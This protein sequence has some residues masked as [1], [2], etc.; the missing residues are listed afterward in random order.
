MAL[1]KRLRIRM[2]KEL[3]KI[4]RYKSQGLD[5]PDRVPEDYLDTAF[6]FLSPKERLAYRLFSSIKLPLRKLIP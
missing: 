4:L 1:R 6:S 5:L 3:K 2:L